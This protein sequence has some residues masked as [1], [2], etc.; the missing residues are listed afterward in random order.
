MAAVLPAL[1]NLSNA[2]S[3]SLPDS[4]W[5]GDQLGSYRATPVASGYPDLDKELPGSGW[6]PSV[7]VELLL[8]SP[9]MGELRLLAPTLASL[10]QSGKT[11]ILLA[12]PHIPFAPALKQ[13]GLDL[14]KII[15]INADK[16][17]DRVW[18]AEQT[19]KSSSFGALLCWL[20]QVK[21]D[22]LR[23]LQLAA[24]SGEGLVFVFRPLSAQDQSSPSP[25]RLLCQAAPGGK[26][27]VEIF[28]RRGPVHAQ[29]IVLPLSLPSTLIKPLAA[30]PPLI[31]TLN[32]PSHAVDRYSLAATA[33]RRRA[34]LAV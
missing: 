25:L 17:T 12:P 22:H 13:L 27:S 29:A 9:G 20:P 18:A 2:S 32:F 3:L 1:I 14:K 15:L 28:K 31:P 34:A 33:A 21:T 6:P 10:T 4:V 5:R 11:L 30:R 8:H 16:P 24:A 23:R 19:L 7:L 26:L